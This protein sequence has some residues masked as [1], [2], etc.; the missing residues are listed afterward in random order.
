MQQNQWLFDSGASKHMTCH[1]EI[2]QNYQQFPGPQSVK[3]SESRVVDALGF[4]NV[5]LRMTFKVSDVKNVTMFDV[6][7]VPQWELLSKQEIQ[8]SSRSL[9]VT[10][11]GKM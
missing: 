10:S 4:G 7:H 5:R 6:L 11:V 9:A 2:L 8:C 1:E 3:L